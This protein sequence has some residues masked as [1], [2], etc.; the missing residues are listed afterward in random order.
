MSS[1]APSR[2]S[3]RTALVTGSS[4]GVGQ[5]VAEALARQGARVFV[6]GRTE[7]ACAA[8]LAR[9]VAASAGRADPVVVAANLAVPAEVEALADRVEALGGV[10]ILY[11]NAAI[12]HP[13]RERIENHT[14]AD[15]ESS[16]QVNVFALVRLCA[17]FV[18]AMRKRGWGRVVN[19]TSGIDKTPQLAGYGASKWAVDKFTDDLAAELKDTGVIVS[20]LDPGWLRTDMGGKQAPNDPETV[21]PGALVPVLLADDAPGGQFFR[22]QE[23]RGANV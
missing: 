4:R 9:V 17:R 3:G 8:T 16:F 19:V 20:R 10:D 7:T 11:N 13:W 21:L 1:L 5:L 2:L 18:P 6:H 14:Q 12:M 22:A 23:L 15:W